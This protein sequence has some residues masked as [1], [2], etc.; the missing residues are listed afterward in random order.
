[1]S[2]EVDPSGTLRRCGKVW[3]PEGK[4]LRM[5]ILRKNHD[6]PMSSHYSPAKRKELLKRKYYWPYL[7]RDVHEYIGIG[8][9][10]QLNKIRRHKPWGTLVPLPANDTVASLL[11]RLRN[12][13]AYV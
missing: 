8:A 11:P 7:A 6:D 3:I 4:A 2:W 12:G 9:A 5:N 13:P 1:V 10:C